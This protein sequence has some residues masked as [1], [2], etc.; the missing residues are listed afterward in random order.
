MTAKIISFQIPERVR[1]SY[2]EPEDTFVDIDEAFF[3]FDVSASLGVIGK[4]IQEHRFLILNWLQYN[5][6]LKPHSDWD[7]ATKKAVTEQMTGFNNQL[8]SAINGVR[9]SLIGGEDV[10]L[11]RARFVV[12]DIT[13]DKQEVARMLGI[14]SEVLFL[15]AVVYDP[16]SMSL[17]DVQDYQIKEVKFPRIRDKRKS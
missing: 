6:F 10:V 11:K 1:K 8:A 4:M 13:D 5:D 16:V 7:P 15:E 17:M 9:A 3:E 12:K 2:V 14:V